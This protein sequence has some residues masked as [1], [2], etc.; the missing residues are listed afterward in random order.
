MEL[1]EKR[2][3]YCHHRHAGSLHALQTIDA[4]K[5]GAHVFCRE[6]HRHTVNESRAMLKTAR[7]DRTRGAG[8]GC[9]PHWPASRQRHE[10]LKIGDVGGRRMVRLSPTA[11]AQ[12]NLSPTARPSTGMN[13]DRW[14][15]R[16]LRPFNNKLHPGGWRNFFDYANGTLGDWGVHWL[17]SSALVDEEKYPKRN[18]FA[19]AAGPV[20][21]AVLNEQGTERMAPDHQ[22][23]IFEF[24]NFTCTF[25]SGST[26]VCRYSR[27]STR[28]GLFYAQGH[29]AHRAGAMAGHFTR[30]TKGANDP[31]RRSTPGTRRHILKLLW[32]DFLEAIAPKTA[33]TAGIEIAHRASVLPLLGMLSW[34][35]GRSIEWD[36]AKSRSS[37]DEKANWLLSA[38]IGAP[39]QYAKSDDCFNYFFVSS[40]F[41]KVGFQ[42]RGRSSAVWHR[43]AHILQLS[44]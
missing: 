1:L 11:V 20:A 44:S 41:L 38:L 30:R 32:G 8:L 28:R 36:G 34:R 18:F 35:L 33:P 40:T 3:E 5:A 42:G 23:A 29:L 25:F 43:I 9:M 27:R 22:A 21:A 39:W 31:R 13:W 17:D 15:G 4:L 14:C 10:V 2:T 24:E 19:P 7:R 26:A 12:R 6:T 37:G 16:A